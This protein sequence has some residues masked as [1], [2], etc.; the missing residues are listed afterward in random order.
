[1]TISTRKDLGEA[2]TL[3]VQLRGIEECMS[4]VAKDITDQQT[5]LAGLIQERTELV[6]KLQV[7]GVDC[8]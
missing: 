1:L 3:L 2:G 8:A 5:V 4:A 7:M 6:A